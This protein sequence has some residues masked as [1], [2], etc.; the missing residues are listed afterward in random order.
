MLTEIYLEL[1]T[2]ID[3]AGLIIQT[4]KPGA[5][6]R[7]ALI[8]GRRKLKNTRFWAPFLKDANKKQII[9]N[10]PK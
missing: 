7:A 4:G 9:R 8:Q 5:F 6:T 1:F 2:R 10:I 3:A